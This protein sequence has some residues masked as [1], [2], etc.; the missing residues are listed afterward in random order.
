MGCFDYIYPELTTLSK[1]GPSRVKKQT[2]SDAISILRPLC[3]SMFVSYSS[4]VLL[5]RS[6]LRSYLYVGLIISV[7]LLSEVES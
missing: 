2:I 3:F 1:L 4:E 6:I 5:L 7:V